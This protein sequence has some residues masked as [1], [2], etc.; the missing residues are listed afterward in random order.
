MAVP[1]IHQ[2]SGVTEI[3][4]FQVECSIEHYLEYRCFRNKNASNNQWEPEGFSVV[5]CCVIH[6]VIHNTGVRVRKG[7]F[8][9]AVI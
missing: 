1:F 8:I 4:L 2:T 9:A 3:D 6:D 7:S 5:I